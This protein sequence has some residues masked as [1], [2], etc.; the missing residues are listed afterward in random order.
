MALLYNYGPGWAP[1]HPPLSTDLF[2]I[3]CLV[4]PNVGQSNLIRLINHSLSIWKLKFSNHAIFISNVPLSQTFST[5]V[6][7][8]SLQFL[9]FASSYSQ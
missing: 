5:T 4:T 1:S 2:V 9:N 8:P 6:I 7:S 3:L